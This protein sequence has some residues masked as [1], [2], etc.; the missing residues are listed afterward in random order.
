MNQK[1]A[2]LGGGHGAHTMAAHL[3]LKGFRVVMYEMPE[4]KKNIKKILDTKEIEIEGAIPVQGTARLD[5]VTLDIEQAVDGA[6]YIFIAVPAFAHQGYAELLADK[7]KEDQIMVLFPGNFGTMEMKNIFMQ[8]GNTS[9]IAFAEAD[10][11]P[12]STR[13]VAPGNVR[14]FKTVN[15]MG[16]GV[17][18]ANKTKLVM[19]ELTRFYPFEAYSNVLEAGLSS[20]NPITH[21]GAVVLNVGRIEYLVK[22]TFYLFEEGYTKSTAKVCEHV[23][24]ERREIGK[25]L[26]FDLISVSDI[27]YRD[28]FG[29]RG[30]LYQTIKASVITPVAGP[31]SIDTRY[32]KEDTPFGLVPWSQLGL[33]LGVKTPIIDSLI[34]L[35]SIICDTDYFKEGRSLEKLGL[36]GMSAEQMLKYVKEGKK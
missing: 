2:V 29:P 12:Y 1:I 10:T 3:S 15:R 36:S 30:T 33:Q 5:D 6:R 9:D 7:I 21:V 17:F 13:L 11:L 35:V 32:L 20:L 31:N 34:H 22:T 4:F 16:L 14:V 27:L 25:K 28:G 18:P 23:D 26:G 19:D 24:V 8:M